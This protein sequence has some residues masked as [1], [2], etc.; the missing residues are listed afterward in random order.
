MIWAIDRNKRLPYLADYLEGF[1]KCGVEGMMI[2]PDS[3]QKCDRKP[4]FV[5][6]FNYHDQSASFFSGLDI[7][8]VAIVYD[9][10]YHPVEMY[11]PDTKGKIH[12]C[13]AFTCD[14]TQV[15]GFQR[16]GAYSEFLPLGVNTDRFRPRR[17]EKKYDVI[18]YGS[19]MSD[20]KNDGFKMMA[21]AHPET[22]DILYGII[23]RKKRNTLFRD[24]LEEMVALEAERTGKFLVSKTMTHQKRA[25]IQMLEDHVTM[26]MREYVTY[27]ANALVFGPK[28]WELYRCAE[29]QK[30]GANCGYGGWLDYRT[31]LPEVVC[32]SKIV[33]SVEKIGTWQAV[34]QRLYEVLAS[35]SFCLSN[36][37]K[38][39]EALFDD[40]KDLAYYDSLKDLKDK[41]GYYLAHEKEREDI[42]AQGCQK[43]RAMHATEHRAKRILEVLD[44]KMGKSIPGT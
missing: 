43:V 30:Y 36:R 7:P 9:T 35:G 23:D 40:G 11:T 21:K 2:E 38:E 25:W 29:G 44:E 12:N 10:W 37:T 31:E 42:A 16:A 24:D 27:C 13:F 14:P 20:N 22:K 15:E 5:L 19:S 6:D 33:L 8:Y 18:F 4:D 32:E 34:G 17:L 41:V 26:M 3:I 39:Q 28:D 1:R